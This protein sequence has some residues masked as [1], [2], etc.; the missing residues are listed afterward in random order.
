M[1]FN[2]DNL[3][4]A[5]FFFLYLILVLWLLRTQEWVQR[6][7]LGSGSNMPPIISISSLSYGPLPFEISQQ[8]SLFIINIPNSCFCPYGSSSDKFRF[9]LEKSLLILG[10]VVE[11]ILQIS[12][13]SD[14]SCYIILNH[15]S[16]LM[17]H[18]LAY[19][20]KYLQ[21]GRFFSS[22]PA[23]VPVHAW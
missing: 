11:R 3:C 8:S 22:C 19:K 5:I 2:C 14:C 16:V 23:H 6:V 15:W 10:S 1:G 9:S 4:C 20:K 12:Q 18:N 13:T 21:F 7:F 17:I